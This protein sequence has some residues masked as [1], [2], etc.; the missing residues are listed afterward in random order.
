M[1]SF[2]IRQA[3]AA[4]FHPEDIEWRV[5][6]SG[7]NN[8]QIW[9]RV[10]AY[11]TSRAIQDRLDEVLGIGG[12]QTDF[13]EG[14]GGGVICRLSVLIDGQWVC[15]EDGAENTDIEKVKGGLS[16][17]IKR[18]A[19][20]VG[21]GRYLYKLDADYALISDK[22]AY[23]DKTK[24]GTWFRWT[25]PALPSWAVP[26]GS[27]GSGCAPRAH[28][29]EDDTLVRP[30]GEAGASYVKKVVTQSTAP[31]SRTADTPS[32]GRLCETQIVKFG[33]RKADGL[34]VLQIGEI[35]GVA[36]LEK[37]LLWLNSTYDPS[38]RYAE[39]NLRM[40]DAYKEAIAILSGQEPPVRE[41]PAADMY[42]EDVPF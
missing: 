42:E 41:E 36:E 32:G 22:G 13:R 23:R 35:D 33:R 39:N 3:L 17:A 30:A 16:G 26:D 38:S 40:M 7:K 24:D 18:A 4:S 14:P 8:G 37:T 19:V 25:P 6:S 34:S 27:S 15:K 31:L 21:I 20:H 29:P 28:E 2:H 9:A 1:D 5:Q 11:V 12:W 10:F